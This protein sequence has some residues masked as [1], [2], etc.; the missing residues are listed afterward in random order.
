ML[1]GALRRMGRPA[2]LASRRRCCAPCTPYQSRPPATV[3]TMSA[4]HAHGRVFSSSSAPVQGRPFADTD[5]DAAAAESLLNSL[6]ESPDASE[7]A[8]ARAARHRA[9]V[10]RAVGLAESAADRGSPRA[11]TLLGHL[12]RDGTGVPV[13][14]E[15]ALKLLTSA[16]E[17]GDPFAQ[18]ALGNMIYDA[19]ASHP[20]NVDDEH[21]QSSPAAAAA[22]AEEAQL[23][24]REIVV[25]IDETGAPMAR[26]EMGDSLKDAPSP[27]TPAQLV[28][29]V[30]KERKK[31]GFADHDA[32]AFE[33]HVQA[34]TRA[35]YREKRAGAVA[36]L[37]KAVDQGSDPAAVA[38]ANVILH[39]DT[40][41]AV[42]LYELAASR[43][44]LPSAHF[45]LAQVYHAGLVEVAAGEKL[46]LKHYSMAAHLGDASAQFLVGHFYRVGD[47]GVAVDLAACLQYVQLAA[48]Q[49]HA[50]AMYY[51][52]LMHRNGEGGLEASRGHFRRHLEASSELGHGE[53]LACL[54]DMHYKGTDGMRVDHEK[55]LS[56]YERAGKA[57]EADALCS[58]A[59][60]HFHGRGTEANKHKAF[61]LY[62]DAAVAGSVAAL[63]NIGAMYFNGDGVPK[64]TSMAEHFFRLV[65]DRQRED[66]N[67]ALQLQA[68]GFQ[69]VSAARRAMPHS[70]RE[71]GGQL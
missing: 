62:Q 67:A 45:N 35:D 17:A 4:Q 1:A 27:E 31:A 16:A 32:M 33:D 61:M 47:M 23:R 59:A 40:P 64:S 9:I 13:D 44:H 63:Q 12:H 55:A 48:A 28:R 66:K 34:Q 49:G 70:E 37:R 43:S 65:D 69:R 8:E 6:D 50:A 42:R 60:M 68:A 71:K 11:R 2:A 18:L 22:A 24:A 54:A 36:W 52:A 15:K 14:A 25:E 41:A 19:L 30:R 7:T 39:E 46:A 51:L 3:L 5:P 56:C 38:L 26:F 58:A 20:G 21:R 10:A 29:R 57:G 53:A